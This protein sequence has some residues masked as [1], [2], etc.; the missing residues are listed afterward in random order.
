VTARGP[1]EPKRPKSCHERA[2]G[3]LA[4]RP[5]SRRELE[6]RLRQAG[7]ED[8]DVADVLGRL[9]GVGL[10]D[11]QAF[12]RDLAAHA[13]GD[14]RSG[15]RAVRD[16]LASKGVTA[17]TTAAV[18]E[19][20]GGDEEGRALELAR[21]RA[22]RLDGVPREKAYARLV[23]LLARRGYTP[24]VARHAARVALGVDSERD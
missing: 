9:E 14:R 19:E 4:V 13:F 6:Q 5:R 7:F 24:G 12:A 10:V 20:F 8:A 21:S 1:R 22:A 2:L 23:G 18:I 3:L 16:A 11:D 15:A 17:A